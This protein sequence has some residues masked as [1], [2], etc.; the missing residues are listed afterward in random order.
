MLA[1]VVISDIHLGSDNC[2]AKQLVHFLEEMRHGAMAAR[3]LILNGDVFDSIDFRRLK[4]QHW[5]VLSELRK[6]SDEME[7]TWI[8]GNHDG[9]AE[10]VSHLLGVTCSD[11]IVIESGGRRILFLHGHRFDEFI[12]RY[13]VVT[14]VADRVYN[15]LQRIDQSHHFAKMAKRKSKT[16]LRCARKIEHDAVRYAAKR[17]YDAVCCGH[18]HHAGAN[19]TGPV[20]YYNSGCWTEKP[21]HYLAVADGVVEVRSYGESVPDEVPVPPAAPLPETSLPSVA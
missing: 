2:Q 7:I 6:L 8:N 21:C 15:L 14:W 4:K 3:R 5:K 17:G 13:P 1:A 20:R 19:E 16:F 10:I 11:E 9:P 18:T 12:S